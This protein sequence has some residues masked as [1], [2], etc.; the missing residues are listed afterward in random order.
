MT[1]LYNLDHWTWSDLP[2]LIA[3][4]PSP[5]LI[6]LTNYMGHILM[7]YC[8]LANIPFIIDDNID[9][10]FDF[11]DSRIVKQLDFRDIDGLSD[12]NKRSLHRLAVY[13]EYPYYLR[14]LKKSGYQIDISNKSNIIM[15]DVNIYSLDGR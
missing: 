15:E 13:H 5:I 6:K 1:D 7:S 2:V 4:S 12:D 8:Q 3:E 11:Y 14:L 9:E 10:R